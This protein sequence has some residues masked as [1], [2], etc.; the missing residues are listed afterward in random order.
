MSAIALKCLRYCCKVMMGQDKI[1]ILIPELHLRNSVMR[2]SVWNNSLLI[3]GMAGIF[4]Y[5]WLP[6]LEDPLEECAETI[7]ECKLLPSSSAT[8][9]SAIRSFLK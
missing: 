1:W 2:L 5:L 9:R 6:F 7:Y 3:V 8:L 4:I